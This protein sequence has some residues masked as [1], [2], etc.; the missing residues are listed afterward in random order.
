MASVTVN[1]STGEIETD[2]SFVAPSFPV[3]SLVPASV[4][5]RQARL[6]LNEAGL[7]DDVEAA[8]AASPRAIQLTWEYA[9]Q[10]ERGNPIFTQVAA[11]FGL[12]EEQMDD[13]FRRAATL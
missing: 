7:L 8:I 10:I 6:A 1:L 11:G 5:A 3:D 4:T 13:L 2:P 9:T 12:T